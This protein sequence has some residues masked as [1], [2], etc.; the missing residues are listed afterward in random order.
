[1]QLQDESGIKLKCSLC[2]LTNKLRSNVA[3]HVESAH[4]PNTFTYSCEYCGKIF[5]SLN[6]KN[7]HVSKRHSCL[8]YTSDA[9]DE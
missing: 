2:S 5:K 3:N 1:M 9:A 8:L 6:S 7:V 4:F